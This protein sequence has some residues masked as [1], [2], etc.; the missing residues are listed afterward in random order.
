MFTQIG[1]LMNNMK[2]YSQLYEENP[3]ALTEII[4]INQVLNMILKFSVFNIEEWLKVHEISI[5][6]AKDDRFFKDFLGEGQHI[7]KNKDFENDV[8]IG[9]MRKFYKHYTPKEI[10]SILSKAF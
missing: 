2:L 7:T 5:V 3:D 1:K 8:K 4:L 9:Q 6:Y 10:S